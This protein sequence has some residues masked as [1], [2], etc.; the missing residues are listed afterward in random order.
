MVSH[1]GFK[2]T[3]LVLKW[4]E[5]FPCLTSLGILFKSFLG[6]RK[7]NNLY[8]GIDQNFNE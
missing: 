5:Y 4:L 2:T 1:L 8:T 6:F 3:D 7:L